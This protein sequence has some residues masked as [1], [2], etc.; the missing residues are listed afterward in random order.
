MARRWLQFSLGTLLSITFVLAIASIAAGYICRSR[1]SRVAI[2]PVPV[3]GAV[4]INGKVA[5]GWKI[6]FH[7]P[8]FDRQGEDAFGI[9]DAAGNFSV[10]SPKTAPP[11]VWPGVYAV[12]I[13]P[14]VPEMWIGSLAAF[15]HLYPSRYSNPTYSGLTAAIT[16][17][18]TNSFKFDLVGDPE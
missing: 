17:S 18:G 7:Y 14:K 5:A 11:G 4:T 8:E 10:T 3:T 16:R 12:G 1:Q 6:T 13:E 15:K 9:T 2:V